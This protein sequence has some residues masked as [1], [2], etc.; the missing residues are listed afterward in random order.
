[1]PLARIITN[2]AV[3]VAALAARLR[4]QGYTVEIV[5]PEN[6]DGFTHPADV[7]IT[8]DA[9]DPQ[10]AL[11]RAP[12]LAQEYGPIFVS[13]GVITA[14][15]AAPNET[16]P[17]PVEPTAE[18]EENP[19]PESL[20]DAGLKQKQNRLLQWWKEHSEREAEAG[21]APMTAMNE[22]VPAPAMP[23]EV[24]E[25]GR[26]ERERLIEERRRAEA[27]R[28]RI[29]EEAS[30]A[31][32]VQA[33]AR[34]RKQAEQ[35]RLRQEAEAEQLR[36]E[37]E[38]KRLREQAEI[39]RLRKEAEAAQARVAALREREEQRR[40]QAEAEMRRFAEQKAEAER[41]AQIEAHRAEQA[42]HE[43]RAQ[44]HAAQMEAE[45]RARLEAQQSVGS[46]TEAGSQPIMPAPDTSSNPRQVQASPMAPAGPARWKTYSYRRAPRPRRQLRQREREW[47]VAIVV[48]AV[49]AV[50]L[51]VGWSAIQNPRPAAPLSQQEL[52]H[53]STIQQEVPFGPATIA[54]PP[55]KATASPAP[56]MVQPA[57]PNPPAK[58]PKDAKHRRFRRSHAV[59]AG[60][61]EDDV[62]VRHF[63][64]SPPPQTQPGPT[65]ARKYS[66]L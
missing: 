65:Q 17:V 25:A 34:Q 10:E 21:P 2:S 44:L 6:R 54:A 41:L 1:M 29:A 58:S 45:R 49:F 56:A 27:E 37:A 43:R 64:G 9:C 20:A 16:H 51:M 52:T 36:A 42:E 46:A 15:D 18:A 47:R 12:E 55:A 7:E 8:A 62:T 28:V 5:S 26:A 19:K 40:A 14:A 23:D 59:A 22:V 3:A 66:D 13:A 30:R 33:L 24:E 53:S 11:A 31:R 32:R 38:A 39:E 61:D 48:A 60:D 63:N 57:P 50:L 35:E 4:A